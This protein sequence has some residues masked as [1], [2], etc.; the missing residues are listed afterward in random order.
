MRFKRII[1]RLKQVDARYSLAIAV[2]CLLFV[3]AW[4]VTSLKSTPIGWDEVNTAFHLFSHSLDE[5]RN[6]PET[7]ASLAQGSPEHGPVYFALVN[8]WNAIA[9]SDLFVLRLLSVYIGTIGVAVAYRVAALTRD[10]SLGQAAMIL[11]SFMA[12][13]LYFMLEIRPYALHATMSGWV[14]LS[15]WRVLSASNRVPRRKYLEFYLSA[16]LLLYVHYFA[17]FTLAAIGIYHLLLARR[18]ANWWS[19]LMVMLAA[20]FSFAPWLPVAMPALINPRHDL[21]AVNLSAVA[22][23][24]AIALAFTNGLLLPPFVAGAFALYKRKQMSQSEKYIVIIAVLA[25]ALII[26]TNQFVAFLV[27]DSRL[28]Y[29]NGLAIPIACATAV[30]LNYVNGWRVLRFPLV[31]LW[32]ASFFAFSHSETYGVLTG[33]RVQNRDS[34]L[35]WQDFVYESDNLPGHNELVFGFHPIESGAIH[36]QLRYYRSILK[37]WAHLIVVWQDEAGEVEILSNLSTYRMLEEISA[38]TNALWVIHN[39]LRTDFESTEVNSGWL[40]RDYKL[41]RRYVEKAESLIDY[42]V[43]RAIPCELVTDQQPFAI[44]YEDDTWLGNVKH[45]R[46]ADKLM[47]YLWWRRSL[48]GLSSVS[49]QVFDDQSN[50]VDQLDAVI[51]REP[52]DIFS[53]D[54]AS[55]PAGEYVVKLIVYDFA[56]KASFGGEII[57]GKQQFERAVQ[58]ASFTLGD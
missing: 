47:I 30:A 2:C 34:A 42:Y 46:E 24:H 29:L 6:V 8:F 3:F 20:G 52:I 49:L 15:Y 27:A 26:G 31:V 54:I 58:I 28:R 13:Y 40:K 17:A 35:H 11:T 56:S 25:V 10:R 22:S 12:F 19:V 1:S 23:L 50:R 16:A 18:R 36:K 9:G 41:C 51:S 5:Q 4:G 7:V 39:P 38:N 43:K 21:S 37:N 14:I 48:D 33:K 44:K 53:F 55:L 32:I 45:K 57:N